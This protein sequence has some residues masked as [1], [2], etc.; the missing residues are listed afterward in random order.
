MMTNAILLSAAFALAATAALAQGS[1]KPTLV[2]TFKKW[3]IWTYTGSY[4]GK[5]NGKVC[6]IYSEPDKMDRR[7][8]I[9]GASAFR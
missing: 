3:T 1:A 9:M 2:G 6:Y 5:G 7:S 4:A 8:S